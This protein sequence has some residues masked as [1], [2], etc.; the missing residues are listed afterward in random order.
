MW[1][2][3]DCIGYKKL[4]YDYDFLYQENSANLERLRVLE[5]RLSVHSITQYIQI[6]GSIFPHGKSEEEK[7]FLE[8]F[9]QWSLR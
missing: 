7:S 6:Y 1:P 4:Q 9:C 5:Q 3:L 8:Q 2:F